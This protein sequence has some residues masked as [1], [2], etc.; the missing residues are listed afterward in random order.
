MDNRHLSTTVQVA[1]M[2][3]Y[4]DPASR[5]IRQ[6][7][8]DIEEPYLLDS[9]LPEDSFASTHTPSA[10]VPDQLPQLIDCSDSDDDDDASCTEELDN[11]ADQQDDIYTAEEIVKQQLR[12]GK[13]EYFINWLGYPASHNTW[14]PAE[15]IPD[16][17]LITLFH[18]K[19]PRAK[20]LTADPDYIPGNVALLSW[21]ESAASAASG[22]PCPRP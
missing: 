19:H 15:N 12:N 4:V 10:D 9:D 1:S 5:P 14:E 22:R 2:K 13:P 21:T 7:P 11:E 16:Q 18:K 6:L 17:R 8:D 3:R 20:H